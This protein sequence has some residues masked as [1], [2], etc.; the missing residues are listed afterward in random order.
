MAA[1]SDTTR[2]PRGAGSFT[3]Q[4]QSVDPQSANRP[5]VTITEDTQQPSIT[6]PAQQPGRPTSINKR[7]LIGRS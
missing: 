7:R 1:P 5:L 3:Q 2:R 6:K 4:R